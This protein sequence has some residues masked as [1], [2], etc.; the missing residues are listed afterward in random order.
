[1]T[2]NI[3]WFKELGKDDVD[4]V[5]GK[6]SSLGEMISN[7]SKVGIRVP[8]GFATTADA[9]R[10]FLNCN[11]LEN[12]INKELENLDVEDVNKLQKSGAII[13]QWVI[14]SPLQDDLQKDIISAWELMNRECNDEL[15]VA[16]RSS[17]TLKIC[18]KHLLLDSRKLFLTF[19][20]LMLFY[21]IL[22]RYLLHYIMIVQ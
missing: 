5:G 15:S 21:I 19:E 11:D 6:N 3:L 17:A 2:T 9:F 20:V 4:I 10:E 12:R 16:V 22:K 13:R 14:D 7:L 8:N 18:R 1:M